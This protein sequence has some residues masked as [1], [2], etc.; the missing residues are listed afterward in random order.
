MAGYAAVKDGFTKLGFQGGMAVPEVIRY[1]HGFPQ[2]AEV[3]AKEMGLAE[4][5]VSMMYNYSVILQHLRKVKKEQPAGIKQ[6]QK[7]YLPVAVL[8]VT[9]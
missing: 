7:L 2:G 1:G 8:L 5:S 6:G 3:A 9:Q 4:G